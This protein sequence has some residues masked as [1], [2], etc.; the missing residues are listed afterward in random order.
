MSG[1]G[2]KCKIKGKELLIGSIE[3]LEKNNIKFTKENTDRINDEI[4]KIRSIT[5]VSYDNQFV[6]FFSMFDSLK[7]NS[8]LV[9]SALKDMNINIVLISG[10]RKK[11]VQN[12]S[13][14]LGIENCNFYFI[15]KDK[16]EMKPNEKVDIIKELQKKGNIVAMV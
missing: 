5:V 4:N 15:N 9:I 10:D 14:S 11:V 2:I 13:E 3:F 16:Y 1:E 12:I 8:K 7:P 6:G